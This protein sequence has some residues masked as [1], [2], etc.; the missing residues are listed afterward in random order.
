MALTKDEIRDRIARKLL[1][2]Q[3]EAVDWPKV[4]AAINSTSAGD[5]LTFVGFTQQASTNEMGMWMYRAVLRHIENLAI[6]EANDILV[7]DTLS[8]AEVERIFF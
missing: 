8:L 3:L 5:R 2:E 6:R 7:D 4:V 1:K